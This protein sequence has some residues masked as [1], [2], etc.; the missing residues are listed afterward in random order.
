MT[1]LFNPRTFLIKVWKSILFINPRRFRLPTSLNLEKQH[2]QN[3]GFF[4]E[5]YIFGSAFIEK[6]FF[7]FLFLKREVPVRLANIMKVHNSHL[8]KYYTN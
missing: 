3:P 5:Y 6:S 2:Q 7:S 1:F 4:L 8:K